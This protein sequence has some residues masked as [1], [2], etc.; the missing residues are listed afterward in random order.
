M[1]RA[2]WLLALAGIVAVTAAGAW[3][4]RA[5]RVRITW[6]EDVE[7][8]IKL[9]HAKDLPIL[10]Y[11]RDTFGEEFV[12]RTEWRRDWGEG[13]LRRQLRR[14]KARWRWQRFEQDLFTDREFA[15]TVQP[16]VRVRVET[17]YRRLDEDIQNLLLKLNLLT[18]VDLAWRWRLIDDPWADAY[19]YHTHVRT[20][21]LNTT[22]DELLSRE[23][24]YLAVVAGDGR[25][26]LRF[27]AGPPGL[28]QPTKALVTELEHVLEPYRSLAEGRYDLEQGR[29]EAAVGALRR[30]AEGGKE[31]PGD[32]REAAEEELKSLLEKA[33]ESLA[34]VEKALA[35]KDSERAW[36]FLTELQGQGLHQVD[37]RLEAKV[38]DLRQR[39]EDHATALYQKAQEH[40]D[41]KQFA[42][43]SDLLSR[44][45][46]YYQGSEA[47]SLAQK[48]LDELATDPDMAERIR[49]ARRQAEAEDL[50]TTATAAEQEGDLLRAYET[51]KSLSDNYADLPQGAQARQKVSA[52]EADGEL[53]ARI[54]ELRARDEANQWMTLGNNFFVNQV[55]TGAIQYYRK[56]IDTYPD[57]PLAQEAETRLEEARRLLEAQLK[58]EAE[59][60]A[61]APGQ[62]Q[63]PG[64]GTP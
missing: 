24:T 16:F 51:C 59:E 34:Q 23:T 46:R 2:R 29:V 30:L 7:R 57:S 8:A 50:W 58:K 25:L 48:K 41:Q 35:R 33:T 47:G 53:M 22:L 10:L 37:Q 26:L 27:P 49:Q 3:A 12:D 28:E 36:R 64:E 6:L 52:W 14:S 11:V 17:G 5:E 40:L 60:K 21:R 63:P 4:Q 42:A 62:E 39:L 20:S 1:R 43:A 32:V 19:T 31:I 56:V 54:K 38:A 61:P 15:Q 18:D 9:A 44:V 45:A 13:S 55:Y